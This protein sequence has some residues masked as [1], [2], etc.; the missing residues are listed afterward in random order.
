[1]SS[2]IKKRLFV[3]FI[4]FV[5]CAMSALT[6]QAANK[7]GWIRTGKNYK[8]KVDDKYVKNEVKKIGKYYYYFDKKGNRKT[9]WKNSKVRNTILI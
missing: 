8:Y 9:G 7:T 4:I 2:K 3:T 5:L 6:V 1:M